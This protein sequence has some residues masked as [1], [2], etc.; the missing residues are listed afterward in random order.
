MATNFEPHEC[1]IFL[2]STKIDTLENKAIHSSIPATDENKQ[3][4]KVKP[5]MA[6]LTACWTCEWKFVGPSKAVCELSDVSLMEGRLKTS[7]AIQARVRVGP[8]SKEP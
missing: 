3:N 4:H 8:V 5:S 1:I 7:S 6:K 2:Q